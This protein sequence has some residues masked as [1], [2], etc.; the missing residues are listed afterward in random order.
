MERMEYQ[1]DTIPT[2]VA[3]FLRNQKREQASRIL[4]KKESPRMD[5][6]EMR[7]I[8]PG[9]SFPGYQFLR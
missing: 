9:Q 2:H 5:D 7:E 1:D 3:H 4:D 6:D 8:E